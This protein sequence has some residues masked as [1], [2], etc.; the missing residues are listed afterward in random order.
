M[1]SLMFHLLAADSVKPVPAPTSVPQTIP[2]TNKL[3]YMYRLFYLP[4]S[5][6]FQAGVA[7]NDVAPFMQGRALTQNEVKQLDSEWA[8]IRSEWKKKSLVLLTQVNVGQSMRISPRLVS[9]HIT[10]SRGPFDTL[11]VG[12]QIQI[13]EL[14][15]SKSPDLQVAFR[16]LRFLKSFLGPQDEERLNF[17]IFSA[18]WDESSREYRLLFEEY[19]KRF[20]DLSF[21]LHSVVIED[22]K[23]EIFESKLNKD[24]FPNIKKYTHDSVPRFTVFETKNGEPVITEEGDALKLLYERFFQSHRGFLDD[25]ISLMKKNRR[26]VSGK[27]K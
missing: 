21:N 13:N 8:L 20:N 4:F 18:S 23:E 27:L 10:L 2:Q 1:L 9:H 15:K 5:I 19:F 14:L 3:L 11:S 24:L 6:D 22:P 7:A 16:Q 12:D 17:F 26:E 25:Q